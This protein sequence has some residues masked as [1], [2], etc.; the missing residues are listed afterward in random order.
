MTSSGWTTTAGGP[1]VVVADGAEIPLRNVWLLL[2][3]ASEFYQSGPEAFDGIEDYP[4]KLP[5]LLAELLS[6]STEDRLKRP[7]T[8]SF[9]TTSRDLSR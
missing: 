3:Y 9:A 6:A 8:P 1:G 7:L 2:L 5:E 4:E